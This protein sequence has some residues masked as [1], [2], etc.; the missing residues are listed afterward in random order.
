M[1]A[2]LT[3]RLSAVTPSVTLEMNARAA[4]LRATGVDVFAFGVGEP[5]FEPPAFVLDA[6]RKAL[7]GGV[8]KYTA[9]S[10]VAPPA[11]TGLVRGLAPLVQVTET[12]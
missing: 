6:A 3:K 12:P 7:D 11:T 10:G 8:S 9:V 2:N 4:E 5:D 1:P